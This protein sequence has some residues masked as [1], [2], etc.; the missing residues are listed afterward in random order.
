MSRSLLLAASMFLS[1]PL[2]PACLIVAE[3]EGEGEEGEGEGEEG[4]GEEGEGEGEEGEGEG[5]GDVSDCAVDADCEDGEVCATYTEGTDFQFCRLPAER[6][7]R[8]GGFDGDGTLQL[9]CVGDL[10]CERDP[11]SQVGEEICVPATSRTN[12]E[13]CDTNEQCLSGDCNLGD[14][15]VPTE[16][17]LDEDCEAGL[18]CRISSCDGATCVAPAA[19]AELCNAADFVGCTI[20]Q[21]CQDGLTCTVDGR[22]D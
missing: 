2:L 1:L 22:C 13:P 11:T 4:E 9:A 3:G 7:E 16:C 19:E 12:G 6:G 20:T 15:C 10:L 8:C 18:V 21:S 17:G 14:K 5:E